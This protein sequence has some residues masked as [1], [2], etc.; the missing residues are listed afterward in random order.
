M[1]VMRKIVELVLS[2]STFTDVCSKIEEHDVLLEKMSRRLERIQSWASD[3]PVDEPEDEDEDEDGDGDGD[4]DEDE[5]A[6]ED[7]DEDA[8]ATNDDDDT[9]ANAGS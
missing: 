4:E 9:A 1:T 6:D 3:K 2:S 8:D 7:E 5:D